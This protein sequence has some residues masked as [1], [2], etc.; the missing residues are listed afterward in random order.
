MET[1]VKVKDVGEL[2][3]ESRKYLRTYYNEVN[4]LPDED[5]DAPGPARDPQARAVEL[6]GVGGGL[7]SA[8]FSIVPGSQASS[9]APPVTV[10]STSWGPATIEYSAIQIPYS[11]YVPYNPYGPTA[12][13][14]GRCPP[15]STYD[16]HQT[17]SS[18]NYPSADGLFASSSSSY[19]SFNPHSSSNVTAFTSSYPSGVIFAASDP[20]AGSQLGERSIDLP[21]LEEARASM[22]RRDSV[23]GRSSRGRASDNKYWKRR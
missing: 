4:T 17:P 5:Y 3:S 10:T 7:S 2:D 16:M 22:I 1:N 14:T 18:S 8:S 13:S 9:S 19:G 20:Y 12:I 21:T 23:A 15:A 6:A 11:T